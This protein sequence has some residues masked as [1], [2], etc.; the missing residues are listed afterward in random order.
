MCECQSTVITAVIRKHECARENL[1][2]ALTVGGRQRA[3]DVRRRETHRAAA[4]VPTQVHSDPQS[5]FDVHVTVGHPTVEAQPDL[6]PP[7]L[8]Q[9][10][11]APHVPDSQSPTPEQV[12]CVRQR[13]VPP[14]ISRHTQPS[15]Q[16]F[17][18]EH[19]PAGQVGG[20]CSSL[21]TG[22]HTPL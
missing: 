15:P 9:V 17:L 21:T 20:G 2:G 3:Y 1:P 14:P 6:S 12:P 19:S 7:G 16:G 11:P 13:R 5:E 22:A 10:Q 8:T 18:R 4:P